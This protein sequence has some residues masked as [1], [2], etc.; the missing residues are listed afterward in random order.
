[1]EPTLCDRCHFPVGDEAIE[2]G[3]DIFCQRCAEILA[4]EESDELDD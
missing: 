1:M 2:V 4:E 3:S